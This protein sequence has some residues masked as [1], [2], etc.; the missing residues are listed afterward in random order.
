MSL[1]FLLFLFIIYYLVI[2]YS[3]NYMFVDFNIFRF[4]SFVLMF[5]VSI[6][7]LIDSPNVIRILLGW[8][9]LG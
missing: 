6:M 5:V 7:F 9:R 8:F 3:N 1:L 2:L 4:V